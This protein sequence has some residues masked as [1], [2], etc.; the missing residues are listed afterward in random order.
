MV[1]RRT[2]LLAAGSIIAGVLIAQT[3]PTTAFAASGRVRPFGHQP[4]GTL[5][6]YAVPGATDTA[7]IGPVAPEGTLLAANA[8]SP[9]VEPSLD[10]AAAPSPNPSADPTEVASAAPTAAPTAAP[11][12]ASTAPTP[13]P[14]VAP[15]GT[16]LPIG[17]QPGWHQVVA[18]SF[19]GSAVPSGWGTYEG[20]P[21]GEPDGMWLPSHVTVN[22]GAM[23]LN[24][25][26]DG[27]RWVTG[28]VMNSHA[29]SMQYGKYEVR[30]RMTKG[31]GVKYAI[32]LWPHTADWPVGGEID[33]AEDGGSG[34]RNH[35]SAT[36]HYGTDNSTIQREITGVDFSQ[37]HTVGVEWTAGKIVYTLDGKQWGTVVSSNVPRSVMDLAIQTETGTCGERWLGCPDATTPSHVNLD[38]DWVS[39]WKKV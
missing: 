23:H 37:W 35:T 15:S 4:L 11:S 13:A 8:V 22:N 38:V 18:E 33:F 16:T 32:L 6:T 17:D 26:Q 30:F 9:S 29:A 10:P 28:G 5:G 25:Y 2:V 1:A 31:V 12:T 7:A 14:A 24:G 19:S 27:G 39:V 21:G 36:M 3:V 20:H 34:T